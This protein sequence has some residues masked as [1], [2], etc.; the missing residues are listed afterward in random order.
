MFCREHTVQL[1]REIE[2]IKA[3]GAELVVIGS[4]TPN[5]IK[6][7]R[8][9]T[10]FDGPIYSDPSLKSYQAAKLNRS[11]WRVLHPLVAV[12]GARALARGHMQGAMQG[13]NAQQGGVYVILPPDQI[14][15]VH[16][17]QR[18]GDNAGADEVVAA[19]EAAV[20]LKPAA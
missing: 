7:F 4:G 9:N 8:E 6:G 1:H 20:K 10:K 16:I 15:Y 18:A 11:L 14:A 2:R 19:L 12:Y 13:D 5:F 17:S 3:A